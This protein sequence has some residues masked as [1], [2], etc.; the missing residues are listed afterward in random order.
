MVK[1]IL[2]YYLSNFQWY[3]KSVGGTWYLHKFTKD[4]EQLT[5]TEGNCWWATYDKINR[6]SDVI[7]REEW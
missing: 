4:A 3:R 2:K 1:R 6:Y 5:F 7:A